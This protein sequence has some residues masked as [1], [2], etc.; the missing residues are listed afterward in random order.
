MKSHNKRWGAL[1]W[2]LTENPQWK[3][4]EI[5][6]KR[7]LAAL[8]NGKSSQERIISSVLLP[9]AA[10]ATLGTYVPR[11]AVILPPQP[12]VEVVCSIFSFAFDTSGR[13]A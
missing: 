12:T 4:V 6:P 13:K 7:F 5:T 11:V 3:T 1:A 8:F 9:S 10:Q 2:R